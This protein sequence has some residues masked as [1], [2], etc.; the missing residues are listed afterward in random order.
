[1][2]DHR[3]KLTLHKLDQVLEGSLDELTEGL[4]SEER[5]Q[6]LETAHA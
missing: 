5:R 3:I 4:A 2:T 6:A 1:M